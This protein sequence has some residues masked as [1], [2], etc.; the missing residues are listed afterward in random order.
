MAAVTI[1]PHDSEPNG[2]AGPSSAAT[3]FKR[4]HPE[5]YLSRFI[6]KGYRPDG[7]KLRAWRDV[8][9]NT[10]TFLVSM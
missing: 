2:D 4:L 6:D 8:S 1:P 10:G 5:Q 9:V 3:I 7:R